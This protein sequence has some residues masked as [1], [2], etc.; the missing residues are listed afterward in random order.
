MSLM[1]TMIAH[2]GKE[3]ERP[4]QSP[5]PQVEKASVGTEVLFVATDLESRHLRCEEGGRF[6]PCV[7]YPCSRLPRIR[8]VETPG[9]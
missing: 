2:L 1:K 3:D 9:R 7:R 8:G 4:V 6:F 5:V